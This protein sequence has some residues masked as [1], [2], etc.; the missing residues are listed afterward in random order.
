MTKMDDASL[1]RFGLQ[2]VRD[3]SARRANIGSAVVAL[4]LAAFVLTESPGTA[5]L[6]AA[7]IV[8]TTIRVAHNSKKAHDAEYLIN[9]SVPERA[10][11][12]LAQ[13]ERGAA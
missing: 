5:V 9:S 8:S 12:I 13:S 1:F 3:R 6:F 2:R 4:L 11:K 10:A 7:A